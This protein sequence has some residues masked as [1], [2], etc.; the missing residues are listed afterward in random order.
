MPREDFIKFRRDSSDGWAV[1]TEAL[2]LGEPGY[3]Y[4][5]RVLKIGDGLSLWSALP[6]SG[7][8]GG[9]VGPAGPQGPEGPQGVPGPTGATGLIWRDTWDSGV[10]YLANDAVFYDGASWF[11]SEDPPVAEIPSEASAYW[12]PLAL[13]GTPGAQ[14]EQ[15]LPGA[16]GSD[17]TL[18]VYAD[19]AAVD[20]VRSAEIGYL[21]TDTPATFFG[22]G[23]SIAY[24]GDWATIQIETLVV[25]YG[26]PTDPASELRQFAT[27]GY[28]TKDGQYVRG[29]WGGSW[30][31]WALVKPTKAAIRARVFERSD[32][33][34]FSSSG[35]GDIYRV[36]GA[37]PH[38]LDL[39]AFASSFKGMSAEYF[40][41]ASGT[42][43]ITLT[44]T[45]GATVNGGSSV[46]LPSD[47]MWFKTT[48]TTTNTWKVVWSTR[49]SVP[50]YM[51][52]TE[53]AVTGPAIWYETS[54]GVVIKKWVQT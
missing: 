31:A 35:E 41:D 7:G 2:A 53:P 32:A 50:V 21:N 54:G 20:A 17:A 15:G 24:D 1:S 51:Q 48:L 26:A 44:A 9:G 23:V 45:G 43:P 14:G 18:T 30:S 33:W 52:D 36:S 37:G 16:P 39:G 4:T 28:E 38:T 5:N 27:I 8:G 11:A 49:G 13:Q 40:V 12:W 42:G 6:G 34:S 46:V 22:A 19:A 3:D 10:D 29:W 47:V 25:R